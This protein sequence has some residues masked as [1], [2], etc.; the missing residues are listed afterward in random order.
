MHSSFLFCVWVVA[1]VLFLSSV[2]VAQPSFDCAEAVTWSEIQVCDD[3]ALSA[4]DQ[5]VA[6]LFGDAK[7]RL[8]GQAQQQLIA[9]QRTW[10]RERESCEQ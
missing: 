6:T 2:S 3:Q 9:E 7:V 8:T 1:Q 4:L 10:L 5:E